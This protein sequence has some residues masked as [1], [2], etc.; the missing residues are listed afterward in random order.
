MTL[1]R[2]DKLVNL[3]GEM[4]RH[5]LDIIGISEMRYPNEEDFWFENSHRII[6]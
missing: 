3:K 2:V 6:F 4:D 1:K 5:N